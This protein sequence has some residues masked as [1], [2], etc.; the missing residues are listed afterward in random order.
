M[1]VGIFQ[2]AKLIMDKSIFNPENQQSEL[3]SK[4]IAGLERVSQ[5]F[6]VMLWEKAKHLGISPIQIQILIF[7]AHHKAAYNNVSFLAQEFNVTKP[8]ISDAVKVL[9]KKGLIAKDHS[10][11]DNRSYT[12]FLTDRGKEVVAETDSFAN[13]MAKMLD[14]ASNEEK[15]NLFKS[16]SELIYGLNQQDILTV[17]RMCFACK[18]YEPGTDHHYCRLLEK[19][20]KASDIRLDCNEF[21]AKI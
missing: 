3:S 12:I 10:A 2:W 11:T 18:F 13:P 21:E 9:H 14:K 16:L 7:V 4:I 17:Q 5:A 15:E 8:T 20:L 6:K 1:P 19:N